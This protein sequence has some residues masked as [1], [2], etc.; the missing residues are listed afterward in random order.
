MGAAV[1]GAGVV[2]AGLA[3]VGAVVVL[4]DDQDF[5]EEPQPAAVKRDHRY[6]SPDIHQPWSY[7]HLAH[8]LAQ[9]C[10]KNH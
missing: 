10:G 6:A 7:S 9:A 4:L 8:H 5:V 1:D 3:V 2:G